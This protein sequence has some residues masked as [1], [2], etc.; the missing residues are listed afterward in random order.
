MKRGWVRAAMARA[1]FSR[2]CKRDLIDRAESWL[3]VSGDDELESGSELEE[4]AAHEA[5]RD[6]IASGKWGLAAR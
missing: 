4:V 5:S 3:V 6:P 2:S 1:S